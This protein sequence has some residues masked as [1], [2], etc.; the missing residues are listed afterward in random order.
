MGYMCKMVKKKKATKKVAK[1][2]ES[3]CKCDF[4]AKCKSCEGGCFWFLG[5]VGAMIY[6]MSTAVGFW[7]VV[8][9]ILKSIVWP[10]FIVHGLL[11]FLGL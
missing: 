8:L 7:G 11:K 10:V 6:F 3:K 2:I 5:F 1:T 4:G 9:G